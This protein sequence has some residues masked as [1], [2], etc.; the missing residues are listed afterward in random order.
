MARKIK[1]ESG[2]WQMNLEMT[3]TVVD[4][5]KFKKECEEVNKFWGG[6]EN[7]VRRRGRHE[8]AGLALFAAE[9][10]QQIAF[11]NFKDEGWLTEQ[12]DYSKGKG[13]E[14]YPSMEDFG[15]KIESIESWHIDYDDITIEYISE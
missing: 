2:A 15:I 1:L 12:F 11:N 13:I 5:D 7:R 14:G 3:I 8:K 4:E 10:F 6:H 9:C